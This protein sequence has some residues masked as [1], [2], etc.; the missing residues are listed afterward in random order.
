MKTYQGYLIDLD[1]TMYHGMNRIEEAVTFVQTLY[2]KKVP[3]LFVTNNATQTPKEVVYKLQ[4]MEIPATTNNVMTSAL[5]TAKYIRTKAP[6][7]T[8]YVIGEYGLKN[9]LKQEGLHITITSEDVDYVVMGLDRDITYE[10]LSQ[11][12]LAIQ[13]GATFIATNMDQVIPTER[14]L[15]PGNGSLVSSVAYSTGIQPVVIGKPEQIIMKEALKQIHLSRKD[16]LMIGDNYETDILAGI[17]SKIDTL[18][19]FS[20]VTQRND[21]ATVSKLPTYQIDRLDEWIS[22]L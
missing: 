15:F 20:G 1:G 2:E 5:A 13:K 16:V 11:A 17:H 7:A 14:G 12:S 6:E 22:Y 9:A 10:K 4:Q 8:C 21:L 18:L 19:V 3:Y